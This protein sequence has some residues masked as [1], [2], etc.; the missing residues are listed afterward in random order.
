MVLMLVLSHQ[1]QE[2]PYRRYCFSHVGICRAELE[3]ARS[4]LQHAQE[5]VSGLEGG[6]SAMTT[7][8]VQLQKHIEELEKQLESSQ[9]VDQLCFVSQFT[10]T[11]TFLA[12]QG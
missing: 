4:S 12:T 1:G 9:K 5:K 7:R 6:K 10:G 2:E 11:A 8:I 3:Q